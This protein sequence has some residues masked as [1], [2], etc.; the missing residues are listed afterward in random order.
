V[1]VALTA[2]ASPDPV[3]VFVDDV[4]IERAR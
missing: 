2:S 3:S 4:R 1:Q